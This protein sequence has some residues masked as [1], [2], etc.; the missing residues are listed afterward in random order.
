[1]T[2]LIR[3]VVQVRRGLVLVGLH[4]SHAAAFGESAASQTQVER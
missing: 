2:E 1:V 4:S 3:R